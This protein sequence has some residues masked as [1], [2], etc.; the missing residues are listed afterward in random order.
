MCTDASS[1]IPEIRTQL[2]PDN[3]T[4]VSNDRPR[5]VMES[6]TATPRQ[7]QEAVRVNTEARLRALKIG[8]LLMAGLA[9]RPGGSRITFPEKFQV[10]MP[11][12]RA[13]A[14]PDPIGSNQ[15]E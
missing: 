7:V 11:R 14:P 10:T 2:D 6:T 15:G 3:V 13:P 4:F 9:S 1:R 5:S 8:L 12:A